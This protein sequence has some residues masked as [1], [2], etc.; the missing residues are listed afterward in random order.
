M[1]QLSGVNAV[2]A[3]LTDGLTSG[4]VG[5][6]DFET[7]YCYHYVNCSRM[8]PVEESV[9]KSV[10]IQGTNTS[11]QSLDLFVFCEYGVEISVDVISG[12]RV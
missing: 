1:N 6:L 12:S 3:G 11:A 7:A 2:N 4:L 10:T 9:P 8:L 5:Q